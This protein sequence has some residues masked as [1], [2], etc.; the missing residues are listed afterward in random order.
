[1]NTHIVVQHIRITECAMNFPVD[2]GFNGQFALWDHVITAMPLYG[3]RLHTPHTNCVAM[4]IKYLGSHT[5]P[6]K[7]GERAWKILPRDV[8]Y[9]VWCVVLALCCDVSNLDT[10][11]LVIRTPDPD[12]QLY[13]IIP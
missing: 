4:T 3:R 7:K 10:F 6:Q 2:F 8:V 11:S 13:H 9:I 1:M 12:P 5:L